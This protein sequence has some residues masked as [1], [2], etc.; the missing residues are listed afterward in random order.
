MSFILHMPL[1]LKALWAVKIALGCTA[2]VILVRTMY[3]ISQIGEEK[4]DTK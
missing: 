1:A 2:F 3:M 4:E